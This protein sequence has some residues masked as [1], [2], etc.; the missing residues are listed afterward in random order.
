MKYVVAVSGGVDS[1]VL[2]DMFVKLHSKDIVVAH[3][4]HGIRLES[5]ADERFVRELATLYGVPY[6]FRREDLGPSASEEQARN[7]RYRFLKSV[8]TKY[9]AKLVTAHHQDDLIETVAI[10]THRGTGWRGLAVFGD[11][12]IVRPLLRYSKSELTEYALLHNLEWVEDETNKSTDYLRNKVRKK[13]GFI[14]P[15]DKKVVANLSWQQ[16]SL[17]DEILNEASRFLTNRDRYFFIMLPH[18]VSVEL[19]RQITNGRLVAAQL[20][21]VLLAIKMA[22]PGSAITAGAGVVFRFTK[23][24]FIVENTGRML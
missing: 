7:R 19:L 24:D 11:K 6:E 22:K 3:F 18:E 14:S 8:A 9:E 23:R 12:T 4:D 5:D 20:E 13:L 16:H 1:V 17:K 15:D 21:N 10:N 2:L